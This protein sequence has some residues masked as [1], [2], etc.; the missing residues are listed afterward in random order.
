MMKTQRYPILIKMVV[1]QVIFLLLHYTYDWFPNNLAK[2]FSG[3][4]ESIFQH[5]KIAFFS[6]IIL[7]LI[8]Y[9]WVR[10]RTPTNA[11]FFSRVFATSFIPWTVFVFYFMAAAYYGEIDNIPIEILYA[12]LV[13]FMASFATIIVEQHIEKAQ[14]GIAF[15]IVCGALFLVSLSYYII[16][17]YR[18]PWFDVF[19]VPPGW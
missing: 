1:Y 10:K 12:N 19:A 7:S 4:N 3:I 14:P 8:E 16:F 17:T 13:L 15:K 9:L 6:Y 18:L 5:M 2:I 11:Y